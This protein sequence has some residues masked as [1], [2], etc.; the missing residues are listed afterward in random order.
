MLA[1]LPVES[2]PP[3]NGP[4]A[5]L[6]SRI[7]N[8][9]LFSV[10]VDHWTLQPVKGAE[11]LVL[12]EL[13]MEMFSCSK[14]NSN[15]ETVRRVRSKRA[16]EDYDFT[17]AVYKKGYLP[18]FFSARGIVNQSQIGRRCQLQRIEEGIDLGAYVE[19]GDIKFNKSKTRVLFETEVE[20]DKIADALTLLP[21]VKVVVRQKASSTHSYL[22]VVRDYLISVGVHPNQLI[23][24]ERNVIG[25]DFTGPLPETFGDPEF[26]F[27]I[28]SF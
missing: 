6:G 24:D 5:K 19:S 15:G 10:I 28:T 17:I 25:P 7:N 12:D 23:Q 8:L 26:E 21:E 2:D 22:P 4:N 11:I 20:L 18:G 13:D 1:Y 27:V 9:K 16:G 3:L 14:T